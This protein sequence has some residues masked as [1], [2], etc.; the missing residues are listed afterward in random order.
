VIEV[1]LEVL[2]D[3]FVSTEGSQKTSDLSVRNFNA[4]MLAN[5]RHNV[6]QCLK[7]AVAGVGLAIPQLANYQNVAAKEVER[8]SSGLLLLAIN[9]WGSKP[10]MIVIVEILVGFFCKGKFSSKI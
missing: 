6:L 10:E 7:G 2:V 9:P 4:K 5:G 1:K 3:C 8:C